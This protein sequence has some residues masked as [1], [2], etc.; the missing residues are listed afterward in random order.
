MLFFFLNNELDKS[1]IVYLET[2]ISY[3]QWKV[4][5]FRERMDINELRRFKWDLFK[6]RLRSRKFFIFIAPD[7]QRESAVSERNLIC[8]EENEII[9][10]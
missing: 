10:F 9:V 5:W 3:K 8:K 1:S 2:H 6:S 7:I 4:K